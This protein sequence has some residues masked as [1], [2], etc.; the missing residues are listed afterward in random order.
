MSRELGKF[1][2]STRRLG[3][4]RGVFNGMKGSYKEERRSG[5]LV[6]I[7]MYSDPFPIPVISFPGFVLSKVHTSNLPSEDFSCY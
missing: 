5:H 2:V 7:L 6:S 4:V 1:N 3:E